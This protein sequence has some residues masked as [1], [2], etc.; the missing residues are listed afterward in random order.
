M[1]VNKKLII[2]LLSVLVLSLLASSIHDTYSSY[3]LKSILDAEKNERTQVMFSGKYLNWMKLVSYFSIFKYIKILIM[4]IWLFYEAS[5]HKQ[6]KVIW[7]IIGLV[8]GI[9]GVILFYVYS[10]FYHKIKNKLS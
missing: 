9:Y 2:I 3:M 7:S 6:S 5:R 8:F 10:I 4:A 1:K